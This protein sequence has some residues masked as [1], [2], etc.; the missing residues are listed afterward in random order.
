[1]NIPSSEKFLKAVAGTDS[2]AMVRASEVRSIICDT[3]GEVEIWVRNQGVSGDVSHLTV[4]IPADGESAYMD[5]L[6]SEIAFGN[7]AVI[8]LASFS[9]GT[10]V[11]IDA[12]A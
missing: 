4:T 12:T 5:A 3:E 6:A 2:A 9:T 1:M 7:D 8:D 11:A 10:A